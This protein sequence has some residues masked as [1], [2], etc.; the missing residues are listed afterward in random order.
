MMQTSR[1][2]FTTAALLAFAFG[3][4]T[5]QNDGLKRTVLQ[6]ADLTGIEGHQGALYKVEIAPGAEVPK[7][8]HPGDEFVY[9]AEGS[10]LIEPEGQPAVTLKAGDSARAP[11][12]LA[13]SAR[14]LDLA[15]PAVLIVFVVSEAGK[16][17]ADAV[18]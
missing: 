5:A 16:P 18:E 1:I 15:R 11:M 9:V 13:H 17:V 2:V 10:L 8:T 12:G 3:Q 4:A 6:Q 7:H 14:N